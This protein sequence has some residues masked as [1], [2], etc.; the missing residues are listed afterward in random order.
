MRHLFWV[1]VFLLGLAALL[2][3]QTN[4]WKRYENKDGHFAVLFPGEPVDKE[5]SWEGVRKHY[6][7]AIEKPAVYV[8]IYGNQET[9]Q[10]VDNPTYEGYRDGVFDNLPGCQVGPEKPAPARE[11]YIGHWY[12]LDCDFDDLRVVIEGN[13]YWGTHHS[14]AVLV[15]LPPDTDEPKSSKTFWESFSPNE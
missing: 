4:N 11:G 5:L 2:A 13:L 14:Y 15:M 1:S 7:T 12:R 9:P 6:L 8:V 3:A 10:P